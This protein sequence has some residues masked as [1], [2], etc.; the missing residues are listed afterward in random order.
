MQVAR[1]SSWNA[2]T[3][4]AKADVADPNASRNKGMRVE[5]RHLGANKLL[6]HNNSFVKSIFSNNAIYRMWDV[7]NIK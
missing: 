4:A 2:K 7:T 5:K 3:E 6:T 1:F